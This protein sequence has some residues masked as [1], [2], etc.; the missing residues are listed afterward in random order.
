[1]VLSW[2]RSAAGVWVGLSGRTWVVTTALVGW[3]G[4]L[5]AVSLTV[6]WASRNP[7]QFARLWPALP[8]AVGVALALKLP[9]AGWVL[10]LNVQRKLVEARVVGWAVGAWLVAVLGLFALLA[11]LVP[12]EWA[13]PAL[14]A[15]VS[16]LA[17]PLASIGLAPLAL[18]WN[19]HR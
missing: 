17:V 2:A 15:G 10:R 3:F 5:A 13:C 9:A 1:M 11:W 8:W 19:R 4:G 14:L 16:V 7:E 12:S 6:S 18:A